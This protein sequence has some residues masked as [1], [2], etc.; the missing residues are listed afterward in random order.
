MADKAIVRLWE[1]THTDIRRINVLAAKRA[2]VFTYVHKSN[3]KKQEK[4][5]FIK[6]WTMQCVFMIKS[7][8]H[9][10]E[11]VASTAHKLK[12]EILDLY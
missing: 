7:E 5:L 8:Y 12:E 11:S 9:L 2:A 4:N 3:V 1:V 10:E 6:T